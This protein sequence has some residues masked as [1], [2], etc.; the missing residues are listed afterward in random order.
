MLYKFITQI[1]DA[2][3][4]CKIKKFLPFS[5]QHF[6]FFLNLKFY[7]YFF[8]FPKIFSHILLTHLSSLIEHSFTNH[9]LSFSLPRITHYFQYFSQRFSAY[10]LRAYIPSIGF[11]MMCC[12]CVC[13]LLH[14]FV[15]YDYLR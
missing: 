15:A 6:S 12:V 7:F 2:I 10:K 8:F 3:Y 14:S 11:M 1:N 5:H 9:F 4:Q 13:V